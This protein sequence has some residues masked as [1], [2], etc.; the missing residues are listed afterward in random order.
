[1]PEGAAWLEHCR[2]FKPEGTPTS[3]SWLSRVER[4]SVEIT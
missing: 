3:A 4:A 2:R 1:M